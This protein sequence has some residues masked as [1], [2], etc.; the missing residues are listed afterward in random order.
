MK[1]SKKTAKAALL[2]VWSLLL[3]SFTIVLGATPMNALYR[4]VGKYYFWLFWSSVSAALIYFKLFPIAVVI[5]SVSLLVSIFNEVRKSGFTYLMASF[6][7]VIFTSTVLYFSGYM[8]SKTQQ[9]KWSVVFEKVIQENIIKYLPPSS[10]TGVNI[11]VNQIIM[12]LPSI[13]VIL[14]IISVFFALLFE[15]KILSWLEVSPVY[16]IKLREFRLP[17]VMIW[18]FIL[19]LLLAFVKLEYKWVNPLGMNFLNVIVLLYFFQG[20]AVVETYL[21]IT[22]STTFWRVL[23]YTFLILQLFL[24]VAIFGVIDYWMDFRKRLFK[25]MTEIKN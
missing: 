24:A 3:M 1:E 10:E 12:Q 4:L 16:R 8:V 14:L 15:K 23:I 2:V 18:A 7:S 22:K 17:D 5:L 6:V 13:G 11:D 25:K 21:Q 19:S 20:L 9:L